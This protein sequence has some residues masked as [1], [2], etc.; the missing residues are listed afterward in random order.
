M[1]DFDPIFGDEAPDR[2]SY[3]TLPAPPPA[4]SSGTVLN[5]NDPYDLNLLLGQAELANRLRPPSGPL[6]AQS[7][8][9]LAAKQRFA[10]QQQRNQFESDKFLQDFNFQNQQKLQT[11]Q[12]QFQ[13]G[14]NDANRQLE[15]QRIVIDQQ[16]AAAEQANQAALRALEQ[17]QLDESRKQFEV[18]QRL[19][20][21]TFEAEQAL[22]SQ[23][24]SLAEQQF[25]L[26]ALQFLTGLAQN[27]RTA[28]AS[29]FLNRGVTPPGQVDAGS[30]IP[31]G[32]NVTN[33][34]ET[35]PKF[36]QG[37]MGATRGVGAPAGAGG[38]VSSSS[39]TAAQ[40]GASLLSSLEG[41]GV[42][43]PFLQRILAQSQGD[44]SQGT[45]MPQ[46][47]AL[48]DGVPLVSSLALLQMSPTEREG[49]RGF[50]EASGMN[51]D[52]YLSLIKNASPTAS[53]SQAAPPQFQ[54]AP[55]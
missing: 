16:R 17:G 19:R 12:Q 24:Q 6:G 34:A 9:D 38:T 21:Q 1:A 5:P 20:Q 53:T 41:E 4:P 48:P 40:P 39:A 55:Q 31:A 46:Q 3:P 49:F 15:Q 10:E 8:P 35:L 22:A 13:S 25:G 7:D 30:P 14:Q 50:V 54:Y 47:T 2:P 42:V 32:L 28:L 27:P 51:W 23:Q 37:I 52:D 11:G 45:N 43:P 36:L 26:T 44:A 29:F 33:I 18:S